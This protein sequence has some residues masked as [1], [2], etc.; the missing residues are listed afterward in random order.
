MYKRLKRLAV[1][2]IVFSVL[3]FRPQA[4][5]SAD[6]ELIIY[7]PVCEGNNIMLYVKGTE[8]D[9][10]PEIQ[11]GTSIGD[12]IEYSMLADDSEHFYTL[13]IVDNSKSI[14]KSD[15]SKTK[16][17]LRSLIIGRVKNEKI[18]IAS[19]SDNEIEYLCDFTEDGIDLQNALA[20]IK[21]KSHKSYLTDVLYELC[22]DDKNIVAKNAFLRIILISN[23]SNHDGGKY[24]EDEL[25]SLLKKIKIPVYTLCCTEGISDTTNIK[26]FSSLARE[27]DALDFN[28]TES[29]NLNQIVRILQEE[30]D[31][32]R[33]VFSPSPEMLDGTDKMVKVA[34]GSR[35]GSMLVTM[36]QNI[37]DIN[38]DT[39]IEQT[40]SFN[41]PAESDEV[42]GNV[43][44]EKNNEVSGITD[45]FISKHIGM[46]WGLGAIF[47][48]ICILIIVMILVHKN[49][50][51]D[52]INIL[53]DQ[54]DNV[55][56]VPE[57]NIVHK[58]IA[59]DEGNIK[60][61]WDNVIRL[62]CINRVWEKQMKIN[63]PIVIGRSSVESNCVLDIDNS[64]SRKH[65]MIFV[66]NNKYYIKNLSK[67]NG[68]YI[69][70]VQIVKE[71]ELTSGAKIT[72]GN[73]ELKF[74]VL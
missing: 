56:V 26:W 52:F 38:T 57:T 14:K 1:V 42:I 20:S 34:V 22:T 71:F 18:S 67:S 55:S 30:A 72:L 51:R 27:T 70:D 7:E 69:D 50:K 58:N 73:I 40:D 60:H 44:T 36:P 49:K 9:T 15:R 3:G 41:S 5:V 66:E 35:T 53:P 62:T 23:G 12:V 31:I 8:G 17:F 64:V 13:V 45:F 21:Y 48:G 25:D 68:T 29:N 74:E 32:C 59:N 47:I 28:L 65:C 24:R 37:L 16:E 39:S 10:K 6:S 33:V 4:V 54:P 63:E 43:Q 19:F 2:I 11:I 61:I 46:I